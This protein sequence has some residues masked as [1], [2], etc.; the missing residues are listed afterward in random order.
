MCASSSSAGIPISF[1]TVDFRAG[2]V[3]IVA[4]QH[5]A[6]EREYDDL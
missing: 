4:I 3:V 6:R 5:A 2:E 1:T